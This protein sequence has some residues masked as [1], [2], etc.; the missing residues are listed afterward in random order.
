MESKSF[1]SVSRQL[2]RLLAETSSSF[3]IAGRYAKHRKQYDLRYGEQGASVEKN[4]IPAKIM[5]HKATNLVR[6][7]L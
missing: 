2:V 3:D 5:I 6:Y 4:K 7:F 1:P